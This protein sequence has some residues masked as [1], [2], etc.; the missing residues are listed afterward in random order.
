M[1]K[2][3]FELEFD[4]SDFNPESIQF[5]LFFPESLVDSAER[6]RRLLSLRSSQELRDGAI[7]LRAKMRSYFEAYLFEVAEP[8]TP[9]TGDYH[10]V[11]PAKIIA[12]QFDT[13]CP[14]EIQWFPDAEWWE[15]AAL[16]ALG[17]LNRVW[18]Q[19]HSLGDKCAAPDHCGETGAYA[20]ELIA[21]AES[22]RRIAAIKPNP[23]E[24]GRN[25]RH[26]RNREIKAEFI[27]WYVGEA[28]PPGSKTG[29][30]ELF[31]TDHFGD[32]PPTGINERSLLAALRAY[33]KSLPR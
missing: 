20:A 31:I 23:G 25:A 11:T 29:A 19:W 13:P 17:L 12:Y 27:T 8:A 9:D 28:F 18:R 10:V 30:A 21:V 22:Q 5:P 4:F 2:N 24:K 33:E 14:G 1:K 26:G 32:D 16:L 3:F 6:A 7:F 15:L